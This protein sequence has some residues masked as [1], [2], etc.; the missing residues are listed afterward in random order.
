MPAQG[1]QHLPGR[2]RAAPIDPRTARPKAARVW[3]V[4]DVTE[5]AEFELALARARDDAEAASRAKSAFLAN[6]SHEL[7]TPLNGMIGPGAPGAGRRTRPSH[8]GGSTWTRSPRARSRW[9]ASS[10]TSWTC[11]RSR[12]ASC[13]SRPPAST[14]AICCARCSAVR[15]A[16][17]APAGCACSS[18]C[19]RRG[20]GARRRAARAP[21]RQQLPQQRDQVHRPRRRVPGGGRPGGPETARVRFEVADT[22]PGIAP[23]TTRQRLFMPFTQADQSTTRRFGGT[24]LGL[25]ICRELATLMGGEV[26]VTSAP[27]RAA[28]SGP[29]CRC[30]ARPPCR[31]TALPAERGAGVHGC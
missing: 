18:S 29:S 17:R 10:A 7:R 27:A 19:R 23:E 24:G 4:E 22:G 25:S 16:G 28:A 12:P 15:H 5:R 2:V 13:R 1:R 21:G 6:T 20:D 8:S 3:I 14:S 9:P 26:G 30:R 31:R 11:R